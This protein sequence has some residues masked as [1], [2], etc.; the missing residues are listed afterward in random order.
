MQLYASGFASVALGVSRDAF[1]AL[2][3]TKSQAWSADSLRDN[4][5]VQ[6]I[7]SFS[8]AAWKAARAGLHKAVD[9]A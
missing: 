8:D 3:R 5:A 9:E 6:H 1:V 2:A 4:Q 7:V